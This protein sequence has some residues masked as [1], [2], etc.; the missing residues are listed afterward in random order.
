MF[1][2]VGTRQY[3]NLAGLNP[4]AAGPSS[5]LESAHIPM[6]L[7]FA[8]Q[9]ISDDRSA[10]FG[11]PRARVKGIRFSEREARERKW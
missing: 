4:F 11:G 3:A 2:A 1:S 8:Y 5:H 6:R 7:T 10:P 9:G